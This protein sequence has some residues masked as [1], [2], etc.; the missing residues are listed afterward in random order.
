MRKLVPITL[1]LVLLVIVGS[2]VFTFYAVFVGGKD[3]RVPKVEGLSVI[4]AVDVLQKAELVARVDQVDSMKKPG[5]VLA[6]WPADGGLIR[7]GKAVILKVSKGGRRVPLPDVRGMDYE[8]AV[9]T[10]QG[11]GF[12]PGDVVRLA[13]K[14]VPSGAVVAQSPASP[15]SVPAGMR[16]DLLVSFGGGAPEGLILVPD[17]MG[18]AEKGARKMVEDAGLRVGHVRYQ[19]TLASPPGLVMRMSPSPGTKISKGSRIE[20]VVATTERPGVDVALSGEIVDPPGGGTRPTVPGAVRLPTAGGLP[21]VPRPSTDL[22]PSRVIPTVVAV[23]PPESQGEKSPTPKPASEGDASR[24][25][26][27]KI[28]Y[29]VPPLVKPLNLRIEVVDR[30]GTR[31]ILDKTVQGGEYIKLEESY[32]QEAMVT[33]Y[34]GG[35]FVWQDRYQ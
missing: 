3:I 17:L 31:Q 13:H 32:A 18:R 2:G 9:Q 34:L 8:Q 30:N 28:R 5:T 1:L 15:A 23:P 4:E 19:Y 33:I 6:Q 11:E 22:V 35:E 20:L 25:K 7:K 27:A 26:K 14:G 10:L 24:S 12:T 21:V 29:Q 16:V